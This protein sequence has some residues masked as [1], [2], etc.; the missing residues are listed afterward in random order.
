[1]CGRFTLRSPPEQLAQH[2]GLEQPPALAPRWNIA[3]GQDVATLRAEPGRAAPVF[4]LRRWGL[5]PRWAKHPGIG[6]RMINA[7]AETAAEKP[8]F[9]EAL[10]RQRCLLPADGFYEWA[11]GPRVRQPYLIERADGAPFAFAGL[12]EHWEAPDGRRIASC[13]L[14]TSEANARLRA[15]HPRMPVILA[16]EHYARWLDPERRDPAQVGSLL[17]PCPDDWLVPHPV[18]TRVND[19][20]HDDPACAAPVPE[21]LALF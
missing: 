11:A 14:L 13:T 19:V 16:P 5:V 12:W 10:R 9:R 18:A 8:A 4:E 17:R 6:S 21:P 7:R 2:F 1:V 15:L 3:P 20:A